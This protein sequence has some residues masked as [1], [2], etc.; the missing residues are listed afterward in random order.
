[1]NILFYS[2]KG[3]QGKTTHAISYAHYKKANFYTNDYGNSTIEIFKPLFESGDVEFREMK[4]SESVRVNPNK[5]NIFDFGGF[6]DKRVITIAKYVDYCVVPINY[7]SKTDLIPSISTINEL[8]KYNKNIII[9]INNTDKKYS[10]LVKE[11]LGKQF[12]YKIF[13]INSSKYI[14]RLSDE[15]KTI[16]DLFNKGGLEGFQ[17]KKLHSQIKDLYNHLDQPIIK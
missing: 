14:H 16:F 7:Q 3:G 9:L 6:L 15:S 12:S 13:I 11:A 17:L 2:K 1:M 5:S 8:K 10:E 4:P